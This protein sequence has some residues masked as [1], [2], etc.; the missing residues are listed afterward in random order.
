MPARD[1]LETVATAA[2]E[3][4]GRLGYRG[5]RTADVAKEAGISS[6]SLFTYVESKEALF[7]LVFAHGFGHF[8]EVLPPLPLATPAPGETVELI[9]QGLRKVPAPRLRAA[10]DEDHPS[11]AGA[12][13]GG[14]VDER[15]GII[16]QLWPLLAV[17]E[18]CALDLPEL[19]TFYFGQARRG[20]FTRLT[21]YLELRSAGGYLRTTP[22][23]AV[24]ARVII[25]SVTWFAWKRHQGRDAHTY[26]DE[27]ARRTVIDFVCSALVP[28]DA[29]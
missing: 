8:A 10:F 11:D 22:D 19:E 28:E 5:T 2:T 25:E 12:E 15:Y 14:I 6:G 1:R 18:R 20:F 23:A 17:I 24:T 13:L 16:E 4:F 3:V 9:G 26:D 29:S 7:H 27:L 21:E